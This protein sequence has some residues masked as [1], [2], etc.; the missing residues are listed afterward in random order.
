[1][2]DM[3]PAASAADSADCPGLDCPLWAGNGASESC[4]PTVESI[5]R[6]WAHSRGGTASGRAMREGSRAVAKEEGLRM[7]VMVGEY[8]S[9]R[10][11][12][13]A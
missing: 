8:K 4:P 13:C 12:T 9:G 11:M 1:M 5:S 6:T 10:Q 2:L 3:S 7:Y